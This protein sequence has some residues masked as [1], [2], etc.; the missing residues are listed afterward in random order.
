MTVF[1]TRETRAM[2]GQ[3]G[4]SRDNNRMMVRA[5]AGR[6]LPSMMR[7]IS[8]CQEQWGCIEKLKQEEFQGQI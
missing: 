3:C 2:S 8:L 1:G 7:N 5:E 4:W 6:A